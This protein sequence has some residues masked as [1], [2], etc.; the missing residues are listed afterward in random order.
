MTNP[1]K[2]TEDILDMCE[3]FLKIPIERKNNN[4]IFPNPIELMNREWLPVDEVRKAILESTSC[5]Y[6]GDDYE[7][8][9]P[10]GL[11]SRLGLLEEENTTKVNRK[12]L[13][14]PAKASSSNP[15]KLICDKHSR[16]MSYWGNDWHCLE[17]DSKIKRE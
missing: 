6:D 9:L 1:K 3:N 8:I 10:K 7:Y 15:K 16:Q 11:L 17:C 12:E 2:T 5:G 4:I 14:I 13:E